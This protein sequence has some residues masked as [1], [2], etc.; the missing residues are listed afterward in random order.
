LRDISAAVATLVVITA[1]I[2]AAPTA[3][4]F[5]AAL[6]ASARTRSALAIPKCSKTTTDAGEKL[7]TS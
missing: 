1:A 6:H 5:I 7:V 3:V 2:T 4:A